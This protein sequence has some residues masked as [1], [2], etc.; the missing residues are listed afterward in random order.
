MKTHVVIDIILNNNIFFGT[1]E[2]CV[3]WKTRHHDFGYD[4]RP[5]PKDEAVDNKI[6]N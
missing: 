2:E 4:I 1:Y 3:E 5:I 6:N